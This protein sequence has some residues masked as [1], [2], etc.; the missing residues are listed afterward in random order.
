MGSKANRLRKK[1]QDYSGKNAAKAERSFFETFQIV[2]EGT[3]FH[4][5]SQP[6]EFNKIYVNY[7][8]DK[9]IL[10]TTRLNKHTESKE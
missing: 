2:F 3:E 10:F 9:Q 8:L 6:K 4:I 1:W 5:R 7:P